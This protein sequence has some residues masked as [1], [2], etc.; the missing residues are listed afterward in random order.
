MYKKLLL[1]CF[2]SLTLLTAKEISK[3]DMLKASVVKLIDI[4]N[5]LEKR[6][7]ALESELL[8]K[9]QNDEKIVYLP[10]ARKYKERN[11]NSLLFFIPSN[12][13][14]IRTL[15][16]PSAGKIGIA[17]SDKEYRITKLACYKKIGFWGKTKAGWIYISNSK[18][19]K[20]VEN[21]KDSSP[22][23]YNYWCAK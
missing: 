19:G 20:L 10:N 21:K 8:Q 7:L 12:K 16:Y 17:T 11:V 9:Q 18:Y 3:E 23:S 15:P 2:M 4:T 22:M 1:A 13:S 5:K 6:V 14:F